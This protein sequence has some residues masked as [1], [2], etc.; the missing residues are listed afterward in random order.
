MMAPTSRT[1]AAIDS[2]PHDDRTRIVFPDSRRALPWHPGGPA[3]RAAPPHLAVGGEC[4][5]LERGALPVMLSCAAST[6]LVPAPVRADGGACHPQR[7]AS[8]LV[9][10]RHAWTEMSPAAGEFLAGLEPDS[11]GHH[12][13]TV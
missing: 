4:P 3:R 5:D 1:R 2:V 13:D 7:C 6:L 12:S 9:T 10:W 11:P 8:R